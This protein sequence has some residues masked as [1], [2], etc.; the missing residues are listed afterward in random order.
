VWH[1]LRHE[2]N[3]FPVRLVGFAQNLAKLVEVFGAL[4][5]TPPREVVGRFPLEKVWQSGWFLAVVEELIKRAFEGSGHFFERFDGWDGVPVLNAR[6]IATKQAGTLLDVALG[7]LFR[8]AHFAEA[9]ANYHAASLQ[10]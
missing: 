10:R 7:E 9:V 3:E 6:D 2:K 8:L 4:S 1:L 5:S